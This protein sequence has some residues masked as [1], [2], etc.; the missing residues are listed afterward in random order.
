MRPPIVKR[1]RILAHFLR[2]GPRYHSL[3][4]RWHLRRFAQ[5]CFKPRFATADKF[6][7][8]AFLAALRNRKSPNFLFAGEDIETIVSSVCPAAKAATIALADQV[9]RHEF[10]FRERDSVTLGNSIDWNMEIDGSIDWRWDL[11]RHAYFETLGFAYH[12][13]GQEKYARSFIELFEDWLAKNPPEA[14]S[15]NWSSPFEVGFRIGSWI[16]ALFLFRNSRSLTDPCLGQLLAGIHTHCQFLYLNLEIHARNNHLLLEAKA[17]YFAS[18]LFPELPNSKHWHQRALPVLLQEVSSQVFNDGV[19]GEMSTHYHRV[20]A[21]ELL[22]LQG[23]LV[24]NDRTLPENVLRRLQQMVGYQ[25][26]V[27]RPDEN[28]LLLGDSAQKDTYAR[29]PVLELGQ[30]L[31]AAQS[32]IESQD[33]GS[34]AALWRTKGL[35]TKVVPAKVPHYH[36]SCAFPAGGM[37]FMN[38]GRSETDSMRVSID[39]GPFGLKS[40]PHHGHADALSMELYCQERPWL[41][42]SGVFG[43]DIPWP[44]RRY[45]RGTRSHNTVTIDGLDQ[46]ALLDSRRAWSTANASCSEWLTSPRLDYFS[47]THDGYLRLPDPVKHTR[48]IWFVRNE[49][50]VIA[51]QLAANAHHDVEINF[52]CHEDLTVGLDERAARAI[53]HSRESGQ[54]SVLYAANVEVRANLYKGTCDP[55]QGWRAEQSGRKS[56]AETLTLKS[57][58]K[59]PATI[60]TVLVPSRLAETPRSGTVSLARD[61]ANDSLTIAVP[62]ATWTDYFFIASQTNDRYYTVGPFETT[63]PVGFIREPKRQSIPCKAFYFS[64]DVRHASGRELSL[65]PDDDDGTL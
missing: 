1:F 15:P 27:T 2:R 61:Y 47:G 54:L 51:D 3:Y 55:I 63:A 10:S 62:F 38:S 59:L 14:R 57:N 39:C 44:W 34:E 18:I 52:H 17:L 30:Y 45:F 9:S 32:S 60:C 21:G 16:W 5:K 49:Y 64:G 25:L 6:A 23:L 37:Y 24:A 19:H 46:S 56:P 29:V 40:D 53:I 12:Y 48:R 33:P 4:L 20:I 65:N 22:E 35:A 36:D 7:D 26:Q 58:G 50:W 28:L 43:T 41:V 11:N 42:D 31:F 13:T 8:A